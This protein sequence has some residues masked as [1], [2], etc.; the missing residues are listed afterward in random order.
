MLKYLMLSIKLC[1]C[2]SMAEQLIRNEQVGGSIPF[3]SSKNKKTIRKSC[4]FAYNRIELAHGPMATVWGA[5]VP[6]CHVQAVDSL[7]YCQVAGGRLKFFFSV[8]LVRNQIRHHQTNN[9]KS[10]Q[11]NARH[12]IITINHMQ[13]PLHRLIRQ[14]FRCKISET[15]NCHK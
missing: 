10:R 2:G 4:L 5:E 9:S 7:H 15:A 11:H 1:Y 6:D 8:N 14:K 12:N 13:H 3:T